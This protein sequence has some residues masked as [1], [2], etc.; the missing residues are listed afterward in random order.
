MDLHKLAHDVYETG[1]HWHLPIL[2]G[3]IGHVRLHSKMEVKDKIGGE[4]ADHGENDDHVG[5]FK[6]G[7]LGVRYL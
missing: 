3:L 2:F 5:R 7:C 4:N 6:L 1:K